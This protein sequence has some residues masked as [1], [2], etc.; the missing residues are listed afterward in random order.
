M[1]SVR[2]RQTPRRRVF[3]FLASLPLPL[4]D[5][6]LRSHLVP[7]RRHLH[8]H[9]EVGFQEHDTARH[10]RAWLEARGF[11]V[12]GPLAGTGFYVEITGGRPGPVIGY[13]T[14]LDALPMDDQKDVPYA[15]KR[16]GAAHLCGHDAHMAVACGVALLLQERTDTLAG[17]VRVFFQPNEES[18]PSG[19]AAMIEAGVLR[20]LSAAYCIHVDPSLSTG[21]FGLKRGALTAAATPFVVRIQSGQAGHSAR[22]HETVDTVWLAV[23]ILQQFYQLAG[24]VHDARKTAV[25][26]ACTFRAG[27]AMNVIPDAVEFGGT[28]RCASREGFKKLRQ[29]MRKAAG[30]LGALYGADV[31]VD[32]IGP[33]LPP[34]INDDACVNRMRRAVEA[35]FGTEAVRE[36]AEPSMGG[37]DFAFYTEHVPAALLRVGT[38]C[39]ADTRFPLHHTRFDVDESALPMAAQLMADVLALDLEE[40][41][42]Q[43]A[44]LEERHAQEL[45]LE[46]RHAQEAG[47]MRAAPT[48][49]PISA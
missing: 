11:R 28:L 27:D 20:G 4:T 10:V 12:H 1:R 47:Q 40:R 48:S 25:I 8:Q 13:R 35:R 49:N 39:S 26:T 33:A 19:A 29:K 23:Q 42:A 9:P 2:T 6:A 16:P 3:S 21:R 46:E 31:E 32:F 7:L 37:E 43:E 15:S 30:A 41:H 36:L 45:D 34:V 14:E 17:T 5:A 22:P 38:A 18:S 44:D 24:R